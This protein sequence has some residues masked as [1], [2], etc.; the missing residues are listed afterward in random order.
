MFVV[1]DDFVRIDDHLFHFFL[2]CTVAP[3]A[4]SCPPPP[5]FSASAFMVVNLERKRTLMLPSAFCINASHTIAPLMLS[6]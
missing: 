6:R 4:I 3:H 1:F 5:Y 2:L